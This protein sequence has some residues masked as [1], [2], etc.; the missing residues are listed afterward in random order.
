MF[1]G[2]KIGLAL[3]GGGARGVAHIGV[4]RALAEN[5]IEPDLLSGTSA[6]AIV[7]T[8]YSA[9]LSIEQMLEIVAESSLFKAFK[10]VI[11]NTGLT[12][13]SYLKERLARAIPEDNFASLKKPTYIAISNLNKGQL[14]FRNEGPL[15]DV[16]TASSSIPLI[17]KPVEIDGEIYVDGGVFCNLPV[18]P[19]KELADYVIGV[20]VMPAV[21]WESKSLNGWFGIGIRCFELSV[22][23]NSVAQKQLCDH[24]IEVEKAVSY[25]TFQFNKY[26]ELEELGY[27]A[28]LASVDRILQDI[29][30]LP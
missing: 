18:D 8:W 30:S 25:H 29:E 26:K 4:L 16:V 23:A 2:K 10:I 1:Q 15:F 14:E 3:S 9:G 12:S 22:H 24:L 27:Q 20:D 21:E 11:P 28:G 7:A 17:F 13:L 6:G 5:G 19:I